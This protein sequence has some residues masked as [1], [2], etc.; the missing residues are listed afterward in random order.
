M[1]RTG[2]NCRGKP[3]REP[4]SDLKKNGRF[5]QGDFGEENPIEG[6]FQKSTVGNL[7]I[8]WCVSDSGC[9]EPLPLYREGFIY[10]RHV[11]CLT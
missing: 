11:V 5:I 8:M 6:H 4:F 10:C 1:G 7:V 2:S 9:C 3:Y